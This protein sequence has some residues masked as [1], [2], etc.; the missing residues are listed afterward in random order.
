MKNQLINEQIIFFDGICVFCN[1]SIN[2]LEDLDKNGLDMLPPFMTGDLAQFR[3]IELA[4]AIN[5][6]RT[7]SARQKE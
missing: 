4:A 1:K 7:L 3:D 2:L 5:R 6:M